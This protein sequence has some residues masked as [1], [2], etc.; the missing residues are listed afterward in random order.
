M[1]NFKKILVI[2]GSTRI[3]SSNKQLML[4]LQSMTTDRFAISFY[5]DIDKLPHFNPD[6]DT[7]HP[8]SIIHTL[9]EK[10]A[11]ADGIIMCTPEYVFS[12]PGSLKNAIEWCVSTTIFSQKPMGLITAAAS[13][14]KAHTELQLIM[15][16]VEATF[17]DAT[18]LLIKGIKEKFSADGI[19]QDAKTIE[20][21]RVPWQEILNPESLGRRLWRERRR[22]WGEKT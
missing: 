15:Q 4:Q 16:T 12:L 11:Q 20:A 9:R 18:T 14:D 8:P 21:S 22:L 5:E 10:I 6:L 3:H 2:I 17:T 13:G 19:L 7:E 1:H